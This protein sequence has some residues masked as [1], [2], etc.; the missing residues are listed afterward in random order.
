VSPTDFVAVPEAE[1]MLVGPESQPPVLGQAVAA[2]ARPGED[3]V[4]VRRAHL[5]GLHHLDEVHAVALRE[6]APFVEKR[7]GGGTEAV[8]HDLGGLALN[9]AIKDGEGKVL[10]VEDFMQELLDA[11]PRLMVAAGAN[12]PEVADRL[13]VFAARHDALVAVRQE[14]LGIDTTPREGLPQDR[15]CNE[16]GGSGRHGGFDEHQALGPDLGSD[17]FEGGFEGR[18]FGLAGLH[19]SQLALGVVALD[20]DH[21]AVRE[22]QAVRVVGG[23]EGFLFEDGAGDHGIHLGV[24]GLDGRLSPVEEGDLPVAAGAG[25]LAADDELAGLPVG[26]GGVGHDGG[27]DR[28]HESK[29][30]DDHHFLSGLPGLGGQLFEAGELLRVIRIG[31]KRDRLAAGR[32]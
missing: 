27:H 4:A 18:H 19:V 21:D 17:R 26:A 8:L 22:L 3:H 5:D 1:E 7:E 31:W 2:D 9:R 30:H 25:P 24:F 20:V 23:H 10:R 14:R 6:Q 29:A 13:D 11:F 12:A 28:P 16:L 32:D 15:P